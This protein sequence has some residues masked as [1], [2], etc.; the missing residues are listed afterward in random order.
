MRSG[1]VVR[2]CS[3][4][5]KLIVPHAGGDLPG[6]ECHAVPERFDLSDEE[7]GGAVG[8]LAGEIVAT[9]VAI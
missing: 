3:L 2:R 4:A 5:T 6:F 8:V 9:E 7:F 1:D